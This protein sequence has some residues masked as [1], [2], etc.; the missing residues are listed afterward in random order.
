[1]RITAGK[2]RHRNI[3][4]TNLETTR[5]TQDKVRMAIFNILGQYF[6]GGV[7]LD[8]FA[9]SG[10]MGIEAYSRGMDSIYL[11]DINM[12]ALNV[13]KKNCQSLGIN[14]VVFTHY[15]YKN[16]KDNIN[17]KFDLIILDPPY[18]MNNVSEILLSIIPLLKKNGTIVFEMANETEYPTEI[19]GLKALKD[20]KYGIKKVVV[21]R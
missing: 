1:M 14:D 7:C 13:C 5:E 16:F 10:A 18:K 12:D 17:Q 2:L 21:Y 15:D 4:M 3:D 6:D 20:K 19:E 8:L 9:G 11:N